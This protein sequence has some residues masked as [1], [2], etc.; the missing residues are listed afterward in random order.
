MRD[1]GFRRLGQRMAIWVMLAGMAPVPEL[2]PAAY[3]TRRHLG[4]LPIDADYLAAIRALQ[5]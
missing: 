3:L 1:L 2:A 4:E 5:R